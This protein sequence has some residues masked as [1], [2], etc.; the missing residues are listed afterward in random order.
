VIAVAWTHPVGRDELATPVETAVI[1]YRLFI[2]VVAVAGFL[3]VAVIRQARSTHRPRDRVRV[4][5]VRNKRP[6]FVPDC[7]C[8]LAGTP[9]DADEPG[10][11]DR[12]LRDARAHGTNVASEVEYP[13]G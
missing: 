8:G 9:Y 11:R 1:S 5:H 4:M 2:V 12:A 10:A 6:Y 3:P 13:L 7:D